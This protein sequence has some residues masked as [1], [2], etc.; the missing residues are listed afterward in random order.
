MPVEMLVNH[1]KQGATAQR[2]ALSGVGLRYL[3]LNDDHRTLKGRFF[4]MLSHG[5]SAADFWALRDIN[6]EVSAG[7]ILGVVGRNGSG[8]STLLR[9]MGQ[10][11]EPTEGS[12]TV[13]GQVNP[14]LEMGS[15]FNSELT[16][17]ENVHL[18][19]AILQ[20]SRPEMD[21]LLPAIREF[22]DLGP[23]FD[24]PVRCYS[25]GMAARLAFAVCTQIRPEILLLDEILSVGDEQFQK[26]SYFRMRKLIDKGSIVILVTHNL[27]I[28]RSLCSRAIYL[29]QGR[30]MAEGKP[31]HVIDRYR[32]EA[33]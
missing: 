4:N 25:S 23:F 12:V 27:E 13:S 29:S 8:K 33:S 5:A 6:L 26:K 17:R 14:L 11:I 24:V 22:A 16:G 9:I 21:E 19:G 31:D 10:I 3:L 7:E 18:Y 15:A 20:K 32:K 28:V 2:L 1:V 30:I